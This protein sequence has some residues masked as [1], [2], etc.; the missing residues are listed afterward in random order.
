MDNRELSLPSSMCFLLSLFSPCSI[1]VSSSLFLLLQL[2]AR[3]HREKPCG[4][5]STIHLRTRESC[6]PQSHTSSA[7]AHHFFS[8]SAFR[9]SLMHRKRCT[10]Y[11]VLKCI[12]KK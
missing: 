12:F 10:G 8:W 11:I 5:R 6:S 2:L 1:C 9:T 4:S 7:S 3:S